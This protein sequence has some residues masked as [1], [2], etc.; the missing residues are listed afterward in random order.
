VFADFY[1]IAE[2][3]GS[4]WIE[5]DHGRLMSHLLAPFLASPD[6]PP[7]PAVLAQWDAWMRVEPHLVGTY[8]SRSC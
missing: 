6:T 3:D 5:L 8:P 7:T 4:E 2:N 1:R